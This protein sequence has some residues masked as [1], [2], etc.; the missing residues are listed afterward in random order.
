MCQGLKKNLLQRGHT[1]L[2]PK[3]TLQTSAQMV[4]WEVDG[5]SLQPSTWHW[6]TLLMPPNWM[7]RGCT[8]AGISPSK[9]EG[10]V[11]E[12]DSSA[13][14]AGTEASGSLNSWR[15]GWDMVEEGAWWVLLGG[16]EDVGRK[17]CNTSP[18]KSPYK[19]SASE[20][21]HCCTSIFPKPSVSR[22]CALL[23]SL[24]ASLCS[25]ELAHFSKFS[26]YKEKIKRETWK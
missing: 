15:G 23:L 14:P 24:H 18:L 6:Y 5:P 20:P 16:G 13:C 10:T 1:N 4:A 22:C 12:A 19:P 9:T 17:E 7:Q 26:P 21:V 2:S 3:C 8:L 11:E 25:K